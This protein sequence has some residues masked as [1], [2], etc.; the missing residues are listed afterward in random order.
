MP[1]AWGPQILNRNRNA[2][3]A[4]LAAPF[5]AVIPGP[6]TGQDVL[7]P[8]ACGT[9]GASWMRSPRGTRGTGRSGAPP[10]APR[11]FVGLHGIETK[12]LS[13]RSSLGDTL[14]KAS[15]HNNRGGDPTN[16]PRLFSHL[17]IVKWGAPGPVHHG[18]WTH[19]EVPV[20]QAQ[21]LV[22]VREGPPHGQGR[23]DGGRVLLQELR[24]DGEARARM[25]LRAG[26]RIRTEICTEA[27]G[28]EPFRVQAGFSDGRCFAIVPHAPATLR[29][30]RPKGFCTRKPHAPDVRGMIGV[31]LSTRVPEPVHDCP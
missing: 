6:L 28:P 1:V 2:I 5:I 24:R 19:G 27:S 14:R 4:P 10:E 22:R 18:T 17:G 31:V 16:R 12:N 3:A 20:L 13:I 9:A 26:G 30:G 21:P 15:L 29:P 8:S 7:R 11:R 23:G 25:S